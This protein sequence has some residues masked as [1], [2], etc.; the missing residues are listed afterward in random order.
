[1][2][3]CMPSGSGWPPRR[4]DRAEALERAIF[5]R[6]GESEYNRLGLIGADPTTASSLTARGR[7]QAKELARLLQAEPI[8]L[9]VTSEIPRA[10]DSAEIVL[11]GR[12]VPLVEIGALNDPRA[13]TFEGGPVF[14]LCRLAE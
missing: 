3:C 2:S 12:R 11:D 9:C 7:G 5:V 6:H 13:G 4:S 8:D 10:I 14:D 1:M